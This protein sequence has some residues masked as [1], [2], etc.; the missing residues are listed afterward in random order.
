MRDHGG[1]CEWY[2]WTPH[3]EI[4]PMIYDSVLSGHGFGSGR[5]LWPCVGYQIVRLIES[6]STVY[7][8]WGS[9]VNEGVCHKGDTPTE[10]LLIGFNDCFTVFNRLCERFITKIEVRV[11]FCFTQHF[12]HY[13]INAKIPF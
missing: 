7:G 1:S 4:F 5:V 13:S 10:I 3:I 11:C 2:R 8:S 9:E 6:F 12:R